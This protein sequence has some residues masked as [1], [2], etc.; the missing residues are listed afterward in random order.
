MCHDFL[1]LIID[2]FSSPVLCVLFAVAFLW[3]VSLVVAEGSE[4]TVSASVCVFDYNVFI[5]VSLPLFWRGYV[6]LAPIPTCCVFL[7]LLPVLLHFESCLDRLFAFCF[8]RPISLFVCFFLS[9][10]FSP[11]LEEQRGEDITLDLEVT[12][13]DLYN[14]KVFEVVT[15]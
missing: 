15:C 9:M 10:T 14:G 4:G 7:C 5:F 8:F 2:M 6:Y 11:L 3:V 1:V 13:E 12:L